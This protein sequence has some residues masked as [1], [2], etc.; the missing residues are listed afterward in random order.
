MQKQLGFCLGLGVV[1]IAAIALLGCGGSKSA[2]KPMDIA[3]DAGHQAVTQFDTNQD[4]VLDYEELAKAPGLRAA[5]AKIKKLGTFRGAA[6]SESQLKSA[7]ISAEEIDARIQEWKAHGTG[8]IAVAC[9]VFRVKKGGAGMPQPVV[10]AVVKF[11]PEGF[12]GTGLVVGTG[13]TDKQGLASIS[14]P[15]RGGDDPAENMC[16]GFYRVEI[17]K[18]SEIPAKYNTATILGE[19]VAFDALNLGKGPLKFEL[20]Y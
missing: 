5:V 18:G 7:K 14:Q 19:E 13:T 6:P 12:L 16:S 10:G 4:G 2:V 3:S 9:R 1:G 20:E 8:R 11:V 17:T 15:S